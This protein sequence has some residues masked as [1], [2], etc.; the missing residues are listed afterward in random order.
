M[1]CIG[2]I[3]VLLVVFSCGINKIFDFFISIFLFPYGGMA[4]FSN[5][6]NEN[7][8]FKFQK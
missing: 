7:F 3:G 6:K 1:V 2:G 4:I 5:F 8:H